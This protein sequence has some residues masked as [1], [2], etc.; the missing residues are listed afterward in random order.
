MLS[1]CPTCSVGL[2]AVLR[3]MQQQHVDWLRMPR[4]G[5]QRVEPQL[6]QVV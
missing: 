6:R 3:H 4:A 5:G 2:A 1:M